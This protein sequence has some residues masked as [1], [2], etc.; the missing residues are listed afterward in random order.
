VVVSS[1][2]QWLVK[3]LRACWLPEPGSPDCPP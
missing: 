1:D 3:A 2:T